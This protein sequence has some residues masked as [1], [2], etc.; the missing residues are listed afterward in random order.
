MNDHEACARRTA[1][2]GVEM[3]MALRRC[4]LDDQDAVVTVAGEVEPESSQAEKPTL[5]HHV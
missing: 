1:M 3:A 4:V 2:L 5:R